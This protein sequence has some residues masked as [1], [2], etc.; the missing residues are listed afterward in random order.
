MQFYGTLFAQ[1]APYHLED[2]NAGSDSD[3]DLTPLSSST[4]PQ[5]NAVLGTG[6]V[7]CVEH[8]TI[9]PVL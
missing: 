1:A 9:G 6:G 8:T 2:A 5:S 4:E 3:P 7:S